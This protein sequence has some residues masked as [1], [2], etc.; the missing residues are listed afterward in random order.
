[1]AGESRDQDLTIAD[2]PIPVAAD[3]GVTPSADWDDAGDYSA[4][5]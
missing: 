4:P 1:M 5:I 2:E 3:S